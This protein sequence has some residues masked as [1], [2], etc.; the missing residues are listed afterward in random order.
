MYK[1]L[2]VKREKEEKHSLTSVWDRDLNAISNF[3]FYKF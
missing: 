2:L 1:N 3:F